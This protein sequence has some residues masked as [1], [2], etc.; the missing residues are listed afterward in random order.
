MIFAPDGKPL[1]AF[2][3]P[4]GATIINSVFNVALNLIDHKMTLQDAINAPR[5][6][7]TSATAN[8]TMEPGFAAT[9]VDGLRG[10]RYTVTVTPP[11]GEIGSVQAVIV[12]AHTGKQYGGAD[13][14]R[15]GTV[16]GLP[17]AGN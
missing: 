11:G 3:S 1:V 6:S 7:I 16:I 2:G 15:E 17:R 8:L 4:G 14:R 5:L 13:P 12:D 9:T 10:L